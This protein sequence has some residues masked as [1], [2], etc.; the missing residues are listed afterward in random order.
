M[1]S[2]SIR[3]LA[4]EL[5]VLGGEILR[6]L[7]G[8]SQPKN[9]SATDGNIYY[10]LSSYIPINEDKI[11]T[12][13]NNYLLLKNIFEANEV[14]P[15]EGKPVIGAVM[16][17]VF[18][19]FLY[20]IDHR[21]FGSINEEEKKFVRIIRFDPGCCFGYPFWEFEERDILKNIQFIA[22]SKLDDLDDEKE[23]YDKFEFRLEYLE[24]EKNN[25]K[26]SNYCNKIYLSCWRNFEAYA[27]LSRLFE[28]PWKLYEDLIET[29]INPKFVEKQS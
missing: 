20:D 2:K 22:D 25:E 12:D 28:L 8:K 14:F 15:T 21:N 26:N 6:A 18:S 1:D 17:A 16:Q 11:F 27:A 5:A 29:N 3:Q 24:E 10:R 13:A 23:E 9:Y 7:L 19:F 4:I